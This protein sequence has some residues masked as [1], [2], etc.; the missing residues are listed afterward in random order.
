M[1]YYQKNS[2]PLKWIMALLIFVFGMTF[3]FEDVN[4]F[5][6]N[7]NGNNATDTTGALKTSVDFTLDENP[8]NSGGGSPAV[9][10]EPAT[11]LLLASGLGALYAVRKKRA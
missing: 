1:V 9:V 7:S 5:N 11:L 3:T 10:P 2:Q 6:L 4:G 8:P